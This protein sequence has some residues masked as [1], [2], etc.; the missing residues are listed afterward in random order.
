LVPI[1]FTRGSAVLAPPGAAVL[2]PPEAG[3]DAGALVLADAPAAG[4]DAAVC[5]FASEME[6][7]SAQ[8]PA[9]KPI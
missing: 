7:A 9:K 4:V 8:A 3:V 2:A 6:T 1:T 5:A